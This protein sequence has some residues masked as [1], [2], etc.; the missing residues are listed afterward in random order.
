MNRVTVSYTTAYLGSNAY[1]VKRTVTVDDQLPVETEAEIW[2]TAPHEDT[3]N[4][5]L[6]DVITLAIVRGSW[7]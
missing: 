2:V 3:K 6:Q 7:A 1:I 4:F 5:D